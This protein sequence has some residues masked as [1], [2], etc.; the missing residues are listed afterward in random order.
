MS[1][2]VG[3][4]STMEKFALSRSGFSNM[5]YSDRHPSRACRC[6]QSLFAS[7]EQRVTTRRVRANRG[8]PVPS[9]TTRAISPKE[10]SGNSSLCMLDKMIRS[11]LMYRLH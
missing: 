5:R 2:I 1:F 8:S 3:R 6:H 10:N 4:F 9:C 11:V 7:P